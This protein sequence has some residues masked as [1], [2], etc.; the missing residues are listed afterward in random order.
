V[1]HKE[2]AIVTPPSGG[3]NA[4]QPSSSRLPWEYHDG[5][6]WRSLEPFDFVDG[7][8][9][10]TQDGTVS[11]YCPLDWGE[12]TV[13]G[14]KNYWLR[15]RLTDERY[16]TPM[17]I[18]TIASGELS[19]IKLIASTLEAPVISGLRMGYTFLTEPALLDHCLTYNDF[20]F[21]DCSAACRWPRQLFTPFQPLSDRQ[22]ALYFAF[23]Q[24]LPPGLIILYLQVSQED[25]GDM[26]NDKASSDE[27]SSD[28]APAFV[29]EY[30]NEKGW[31]Q[32]GVRDETLGFQLDGMIQFIGPIDALQ[33]PGIGGNLYRVRARLKQGERLHTIPVHGVW[34]NAAWGSHQFPVTGDPL[35]NSNG[36]PHQTFYFRHQHVPVLEGEVIEILEWTGS[37]GEWETVVQDVAATDVRFAYDLATNRV[38]AVWVRWHTRPH[39]FDSGPNDRHC[40]IERASGWLRFGDNS[41]G[42]IPPAGARV[43]ASY[44]SGGGVSGNVPAGA[45]SELRAGVPYLSTF[46]N[47]AAATGGADVETPISVRARGPQRLRHRDR[48]VSAQDFEWLA[49]EASPAVARVRCLPITGPVGTGQC[50]WVT[51]VI[52]PYGEEA[53]P[54]PTAELRRRVRNHLATR[55]PA[56]VARHIRVIGPHYFPVSVVAEIVPLYASE[57]AQVEACLLA[58]LRDFLHPLTGGP[59]KQGWA[60]GE[61]L[62]QSHIAALIENTVGIDYAPQI[63]LHVNGELFDE[64]V[65]LPA[66]AMI[67]AGAHELKISLGN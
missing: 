3:N 34:L 33:S 6:A 27:V 13:N 50:G 5:K 43:I 26:S 16:G 36:N 25:N 41:H 56:T 18:E 31:T 11:F 23:D 2:G 45:I 58:G 30:Q 20:A 21:S 62:Y 46:N 52:I 38:K 37:G 66:G 32:I 53:Q 19:D 67:A 49:R 4:N 24:P 60:F 10:F 35:G 14:T 54:R 51:L 28:E 12:S 8:E 64:F 39:L 57:A 44:G 22:P 65:T 63:S 48:A 55:V 29:W 15:V 9:S 17:H 7:T 61:P 42:R 1:T 47:P 40:I 59:D